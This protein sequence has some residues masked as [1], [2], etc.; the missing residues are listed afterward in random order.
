MRREIFG[1]LP[2]AYMFPLVLSFLRYSLRFK[3][4]FLD[5]SICHLTYA[6]LDTPGVCS[7]RGFALSE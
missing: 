2:S 5:C 1:K 3:L 7:T 6:W 4:L